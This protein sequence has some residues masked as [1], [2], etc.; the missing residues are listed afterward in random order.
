MRATLLTGV[1][2]KVAARDAGTEPAPLDDMDRSVITEPTRDG[3]MSVTQVPGKREHLPGTRLHSDRP[4]D[5]PQ[6]VV[7][8][9]CLTATTP[10]S[11]QLVSSSL[12]PMPRTSPVGIAG[13]A[14]T[15]TPR[16]RAAHPRA[17][18]RGRQNRTWSDSSQGL[19]A[20]WFCLTATYSKTFDLSPAAPKP[21]RRLR[22]P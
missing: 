12:V 11:G 9:L 15:W 2:D 1:V 7:Q 16:A 17:C 13:T 20:C 22:P 10:Y 6:G 4:A 21:Q 14:L 19:F 3:R 18:A 5:R 8:R